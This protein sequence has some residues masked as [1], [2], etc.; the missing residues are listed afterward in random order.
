[1]LTPGLGVS[2]GFKTDTDISG[3][4]ASGE[5]PLQRWVPPADDLG[6]SLESAG[7]TAEWDQFSAN[8]RMF[9]VKSDYDEN[10]YTT[11]INR[12]D[13]HFAERAA[14][15]DRLAREIEAEGSQY[16][17]VREERG[18]A[19]TDDKDLD[20]ES[21]YVIHL[22]DFSISLTMCRYSGVRREIT[23][24]PSGGAN[25]YTP[26]ARRPPTGQPTVPG[27][28]VDPAIISSQIARPDYVPSKPAEPPASAT[29]KTIAPEA[30]TSKTT[31]KA[32]PSASSQPELAKDVKGKPEAVES[33]PAVKPSVALTPA[34]PT[35]AAPASNDRKPGPSGNAVVSIEGRLLN[36]FK[37]FSQKE[38]AHI[39]QQMSDRAA[40]ASHNK[41]AKLNELKKFSQNFKLK[42][43]VPEDLVPILAKDETKQKEIVEKAHRAAQEKVSSSSTPSPVDVKAVAGPS[44]GKSAVTQPSP[45]ATADRHHGQRPRQGQ[46]HFSSASRGGGQNHGINQ[47][48]R[49]TGLLSTRLAL[50]QQQIKQQGAVPYNN[51]PHPI[52]TQ[53]KMHDIKAP[54]GPSAPSSGGATPTLSSR[55]NVRAHEFRPNPAAS[56]F[57]PVQNATSSSP[58]PGSA[59]KQEPLRKP[60]V[61]GFFGNQRPTVEPLDSEQDFNIL[62]HLKEV[63]AKQLREAS[64]GDVGKSSRE[65][66]NIHTIPPPYR[67]HPRWPKGENIPEDRTGTYIQMLETQAT[68]PNATTHNGMNNGPQ[69]QQQQQFPPH[70]QGPPPQNHTP[71]H[72]PRH[73]AVQPHH[74]PA[75][76][77]QFEAHNMQYSHSTSSMHPSPRPMHPY[78]H[79]GTQPQGMP[80][81]QQQPQVAPYG[82]S[83]VVPHAGLRQQGGPQFMN[84]AVPNM[85][86]QMMTNQPSNGPY[87]G[88][89]ANPQAQMYSPGPG[90]A[91]PHYPNQMGGPAT[92]NGYPS[93]RPGAPMMH[94]QGSQ[95]GHQQ[96]MVYMPQGA[97]MFAQMPPGSSKCSNPARTITFAYESSVPPM[98]QQPYPQHHQPHFG[99]SPQQHHQFPQQPHRGT[100]SGTYAQPMVQQHSMPPQVAPPSGPNGAH[101]QDSTEEVK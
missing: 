99:H 47:G 83:P 4:K 96:P 44:T 86:G 82:M 36:S 19:S 68:V 33:A 48:P 54:S 38:R 9:G 70:L 72:T 97:P 32:E 31:T 87:M 27:A 6:H 45:S 56:A 94:H 64:A 26:P 100:P 91:Y 66:A 13:P 50:N 101:G 25:K 65:N 73:P 61:T 37:Q 62:K 35:S 51:I 74:G 69:Q 67:T 57:Q 30:A 55:F 52:P 16:A 85:G 78:M 24:L 58:R 59:T 1:M 3:N 42:T 89:P 88:M 23:P 17:H 92:A 43:P 22:Y 71:H 20:E 46:A 95:Q 21:K 10:I 11:T 53:D 39:S 41:T 84:P 15:A 14:R 40:R 7:G 34:A 49:N 81:F 5:R 98:R 90:P 77:P 8:E 2:T 18:L 60:P 12:S 80:A 28:P 29:Q 63:Q 75:G 79:Y 76:P 93:P